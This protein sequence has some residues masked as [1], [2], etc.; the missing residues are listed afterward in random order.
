MNHD[1]RRI[2][3]C[4]GL[5]ND[6]DPVLEQAV[7][8]AVATRSELDVLHAVKSLSDD[9]ANTL[10]ESIP[11]RRVL[12]SLSERRRGDANKKLEE[13][14]KAFWDTHPDLYKSFGD[15]K[16][17][18]YVIEGYPAS[19]ITHF[20]QQ[21]GSNMI[22]LAANKRRI[23]ATYAGKITKGVIKR[24]RVPVVVVPSVND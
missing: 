12:E 9:V 3:C 15:K 21:K 11:D 17:K 22:V 2:L 6:S 14:I 16:L 10:R 5:K 8:L 1:I 24:A 13:Q 20:A 19:A 7:R 18:S 23:S 4:I